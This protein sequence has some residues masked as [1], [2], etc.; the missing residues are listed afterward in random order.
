MSTHV[1]GFQSFYIASFCISQTSQ[2]QHKGRMGKT[3]MVCIGRV[4]FNPFNAEA[5]YFCPRH[6]DG[7]IIENHLNLVMLVFIG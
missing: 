1:P 7:D 4:Q 5:G 2:H 3:L 6:K